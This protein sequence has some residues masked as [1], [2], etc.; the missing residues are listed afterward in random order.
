MH[1]VPTGTPVFDW[2][3]PKEWNI[4]D[5]WIKD[6]DGER[7][8]DFRASNLHVV[9]YSVPVHAR[10]SLAELR[11]HLHTLPEQPELDPLPDLVLRARHWGF[12]LPPAAA[13]R[14]TGR[15]VRGLHRLDARAWPPHAR[16]V[17]RQG[18]EHEE[19]LVSATSAT[20]RF[21][22][23]AVEALLVEH[24]EALEPPR[25]SRR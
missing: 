15:R 2:T 11:P 12:C 21:D 16:R 17:R 1:E 24:V 25:R 14:A 5:A 13:R 20:R 6:A 7:V 19:V 23:R 10:M 18:R 22:E 9:S 3:V 8:V 4:R